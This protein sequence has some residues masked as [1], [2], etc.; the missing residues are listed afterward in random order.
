MADEQVDKKD[1]YGYDESQTY[2]KW[3]N[4]FFDGT[5]YAHPA[6][7]RGYDKAAD[8]L[9]SYLLSILDS[10]PPF[11]RPNHND[12]ALNELVDRLIDFKSS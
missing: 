4:P 11:K 6:W 8:D 2:T 7:I 12:P 3:D 1:R 9:I 10:V 5:D